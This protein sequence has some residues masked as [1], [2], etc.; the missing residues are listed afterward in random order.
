MSEPTD[1]QA[2][3]KAAAP[4]PLIQRLAAIKPSDLV[5]LFFL[6]VLVGMILAFLDVNPANLWVDFFGA[7]TE[8]WQRFFENLGS[9]LGWALQY[10]FLGAVI[11]VPIWLLF[12]VLR[13]L[14][15][16]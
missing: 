5:I 10:F 12:H 13:A 16:K 8:A 6:C 1:P 4:R 3:P 2:A 7:V 14:S 11:I 15:N 9:A